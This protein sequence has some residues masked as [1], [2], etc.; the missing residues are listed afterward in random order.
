MRPLGIFLL[1]S[2]CVSGVSVN[3]SQPLLKAHRTAMEII[4]RLFIEAAC[5]RFITILVKCYLSH[6]LSHSSYSFPLDNQ[7]AGDR[8]WPD[9]LLLSTVILCLEIKPRNNFFCSLKPA[10]R[11]NNCLLQELRSKVYHHSWGAGSK[12][13]VWL[14]IKR[15]Q[16]S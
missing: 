5:R 3:N 2:N 7:K 10:A 16:Q 4:C 13:L 11:A 8:S 15:D 14:V 12:V 6:S 1:N 9:K